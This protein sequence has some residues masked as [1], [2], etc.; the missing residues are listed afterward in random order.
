METVSFTRMEDGTREDYE[1][2]E[3]LEREYAAGTADRVLAHLQ[4]L[5]GSLGGYRIDRLEHSL[6]TATRAYRRQA[7][8]ELVVAALLHDIG[9]LLAPHNHSQLAAVILKPYVSRQ[10]HWIIRHHGLFQT[11]YYAHHSG[12]DRHARDRYREHPCYQATVDF[13]QLYD[14]PSFDPD[15]NSLPL[16]FFEPMVRQIFAREPYAARQ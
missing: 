1:L 8:T 7:D 13:C 5:R 10:T 12:G 3:R 6:Q 14:Q 2:L 9:D 15:Y 4:E 16:D 11:Y